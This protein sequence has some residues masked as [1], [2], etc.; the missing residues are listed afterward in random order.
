MPAPLVAVQ[1]VGADTDWPQL[2]NVN[3]TD[4]PGR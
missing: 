4:V 3:V 1:S 2:V